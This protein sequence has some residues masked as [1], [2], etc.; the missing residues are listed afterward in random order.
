MIRIQFIT[1]F[2]LCLGFAVVSHAQ[3]NTQLISRF[4]YSVESTDIWGYVAPDGTEYALV[5]L[6]N[7]VSI[8]SLADPVNPQE[9]AF[10]EGDFSRWR[11]IKTF[12][13]FAYVTAD[14]P[15]SREGLQIIDLSNLP[16]EVSST[17]WQ[18]LL[19]NVE[20]STI[21]NLYID[22]RGICYLSGSNVSVGEVLLV[23]VA[24]TP[25]EPIFIGTNDSEY[26][27]DAYVQ[28]N[29]L[30]SSEIFIG[31]L[32][33]SDVSDPANP[34]LLAAQQTPFRFTHN[35][36]AST[37]GNT[38][39]TT[40]ER[41]NAPVAAYDISDINNIRLLDQFRPLATI[42]QG[43]IPHNVHVLDDYLVI[44]HY[45][46]GLVIVDASRPD[47]L[48]EVGNYDTSTGFVNNFHGAWGAYPFLPSGL[49]LVSDI[50]RGLFVI[51]PDYIRAARLEGQVTDA[52]SG[53]PIRDVEISINTDELFEGS[54]DIFGNYKTGLANAGTYEVTISKLGYIPQTTTVTL[55]NG[56]VTILDAALTKRRIISVNINTFNASNGDDLEDIQVRLV[57]LDT[58]YTGATNAE[59]NLE[60]A[61]IFEDE[62]E[63]IVGAWGYLTEVR[64]SVDIG[65]TSN[66]SLGLSEGFQ[67]DFV[68]DYEWQTS[69][70]ARAG[71]WVRDVPNGTT[72]DGLFSNPNTDIEG[73]I[74][75][76]CYITGNRGTGTDAGIDDVDNGT[77][78]LISPPFNV[79]DIPAAELTFHVWFFNAGGGQFI[80]DEFNIFLANSSDT[81]LIHR[82]VGS[83]NNEWKEVKVRIDSFID[84]EEDLVF[85]ARTADLGDPHL[86]EAGIDGFRIDTGNI[87]TST[88]DL[89]AIE[90]VPGISQIYPNP[91]QSELTIEILEDIQAT[92]RQLLIW[93]S[94]GQLLEQW[95]VNPGRSNISLGNQYPS[96]LYYLQLLRDGEP[97]D[98]QKVIKQ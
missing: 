33:I 13:S 76:S 9:V 98:N 1:A 46:D 36:W 82:V 65:E 15:G 74:G 23:D 41:A 40:D 56:E 32:T 66:V 42:G 57:G 24:T 51:E 3:L 78:T 95:N 25:G 77:V 88:N 86:V 59:G 6:L 20:L 96:G 93:N 26:S 68:L 54:T 79:Q 83:T 18:P 63:V 71:R 73:D 44:S 90:Q 31:Q 19:F 72:F 91:F 12:G 84:I 8:V 21:H 4:S 87:S 48:I 67:D 5:G 22:D 89:S 60:I 28:N 61:Q 81:I 49:I 50:E 17:N 16:E 39:F 58:F 64:S 10:V 34:I 47:N 38:V 85:V 75:N 53:V 43:V 97:V 35:A 94:Y 27:H 70:D 37:D 80:D 29:L 7:G 92:S 62:Y 2:L 69:G 45:T 11:D 30:F 55:N 52:D 14:E